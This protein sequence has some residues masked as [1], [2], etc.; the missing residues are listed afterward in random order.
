MSS[1]KVVWPSR[2]KINVQSLGVTCKFCMVLDPEWCLVNVV[3]ESSV[4]G[5]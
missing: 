5:P 2:V 3:I 4:P 1:T